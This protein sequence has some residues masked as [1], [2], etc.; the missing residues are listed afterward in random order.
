M[1]FF[2]LDSKRSPIF[3]YP[4]RLSQVLLSL[5]YYLLCF[6][7]LLS[8]LPFHYSYTS[9][10]LPLILSFLSR[11]LHFCL[12]SSL[13]PFH[14]VF[15][16]SVSLCLSFFSSVCLS[17][18]VSLWVAQI[19]LWAMLDRQDDLAAG[20]FSWWRTSSPGCREVRMTISHFSFSFSSLSLF[21]SCSDSPQFFFFL[22]LS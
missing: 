21:F 4:L 18:T 17:L 12:S 2:Q 20:L 19:Y 22:R 11:Y 3:I 16:P 14:P 8:S 6:P 7:V 1:S 10:F 5:F 13:S 9:F 15:Y